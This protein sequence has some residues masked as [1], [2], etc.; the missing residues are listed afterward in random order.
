L[1]IKPFISAQLQTR[2]H[3]AKPGMLL[4]ERSGVGGAPP[5]DTVAAL[6]GGNVRADQRSAP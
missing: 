5:I 4:D 1:S 6:P 3:H 2:A